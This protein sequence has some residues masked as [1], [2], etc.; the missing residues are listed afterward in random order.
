VSIISKDSVIVK[1]ARN[2][3][4]LSLSTITEK[5]INDNKNDIIKAQQEQLSTGTRGDGKK[6]KPDYS[7]NTAAKKGFKTPNLFDTGDMYKGLDIIVGVPNDKEYTMFSDVDYFPKLN[8]TYDK[9]FELFK[10]SQKVPSV[11]NDILKNY[12]IAINK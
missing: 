1:Q 11:N 5:S 4:K 8:E 9:A 7:P 10:P 2:I 3:S 12:H 6:I